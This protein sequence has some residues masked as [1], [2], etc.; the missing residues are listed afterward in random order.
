MED[1][2]NSQV[3]VVVDALST[4]QYFAPHL[5]KRGYKCVH[6]LSSPNASKLLLD[7]FHPHDFIENIIYRGD[8]KSVV[9]S[10]KTHNVILVIPGSELGVEMADNLSRQLGLPRNDTTISLARRNKYMMQENVRARGLRAIKEKFSTNLNEILSW[11]KAQNVFPVVLKPVED[12][13]TEGVHFCNSLEEIEKAYNSIMH[14][15]NTL[16]FENKAVLAQERIKG[17]ECIVNTVSFQGKHYITDHWQYR[18]I[19]S[20]DSSPIYDYGR[21]IPHPSENNHELVKYDSDVLDALGFQNG[22]AHAEIMLTDTGP[23]LIEVGAR[24]MGASMP[25]EIVSECIGHNQLDLTIDCFLNHKH[26]LKQ[27]ERPYKIVKHCMMKILIS[28]K[29][30]QIESVPGKEII[31]KLSSAKVVRIPVKSGDS[32]ARTVDLFTSP[33]EVL[34]VNSDPAILEADYKR[35]C[36]LENEGLFQYKS[37]V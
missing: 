6:V 5:K 17:T 33:G 32:I 11:A 13:G 25:P 35:I 27:V 29:A 37:E 18:K 28:Y 16:G 4:G 3:V 2:K 21:L 22:P 10:L 36:E 7:T 31:E 26:F 30:G 19:I 23:V 34:L 24:V 12:A 9:N 15:I 20:E 8:I 1:S 14:H